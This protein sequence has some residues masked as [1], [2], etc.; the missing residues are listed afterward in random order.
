M[1]YRFYNPA[2][3]LHDLLGT[4]PCI[5]GS[6]AFYAAGTTTP[7]VTWADPDQLVPNPNPITLDG[8]GRIS[9]DVWL[10]GAYSIVLKDQDGVTVWT[11][12]VDS[13]SGAGQAIP[14]LITGQFL[15]NDGSNLAWAPILELPD[16]TGSE[17]YT[18]Q[19]QSGQPQWTPPAEIP[20]PPEPEYNVGETSLRIGN[21]LILMG[22]GTAPASGAKRTS[23]NIAFATPFTSLQHVSVTTTIAAATASGALVDNSVTGWTPGMASSGVTVNFDVSDDDTRSNWSI[24]NTVAFSWMAI[25]K[26][27]Q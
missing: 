24:S 22:T 21:M 17:G 18:L 11:R 27:A 13:G 8:S 7:K 3:V 2:P 14:T 4:E 23:A 25:G 10:D 15:T 19:V 20:E 12:D 6:I 9:N 16:P 26:V 1:A 5:D